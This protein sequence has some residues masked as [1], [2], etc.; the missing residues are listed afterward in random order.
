MGRYFRA[1]L[2]ESVVNKVIEH[3]T[4]MKCLLGIT[5]ALI[6]LGLLATLAL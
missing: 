5:G 2:Q 4:R 6:L 3:A 1:L